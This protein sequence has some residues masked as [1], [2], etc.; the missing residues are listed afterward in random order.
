METFNRIMWNSSE[1]HKLLVTSTVHTYVC[2]NCA[3]YDTYYYCLIIGAIEWHICVYIHSAA[4][5]VYKQSI[6]HP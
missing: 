3:T 2:M 4:V 6:F 5:G 1:L